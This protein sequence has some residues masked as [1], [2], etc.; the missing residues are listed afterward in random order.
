VTA[1]NVRAIN[2]IPSRVRYLFPSDRSS[3]AA[4]PGFAGAFSTAARQAAE[5]VLDVIRRFFT[6]GV[7]ETALAPFVIRVC[8]D[9]GLDQCTKH[10]MLS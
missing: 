9:G 1:P 2:F 4:L 3:A 7:T 10:A 5:V 8:I 6:G